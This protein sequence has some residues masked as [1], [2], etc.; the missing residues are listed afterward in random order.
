MAGTTRR[1]YLGTAGIALGS[2]LSAACD[3]SLPL[4]GQATPKSTVRFFIRNHPRNQANRP[5][6]TAAFT[7]KFPSIA[8]EIEWHGAKF[9]IPEEA[10][11]SRVAAGTVPDVFELAEDFVPRAAR[12]SWA[13]DLLPRLKQDQEDA[14]DFY[15]AVL[16]AGRYAGIQVALPEAWS[17]HVMYV[18]RGL[19]EQAQLPLPDHTWTYD[20]W[21]EAAAR[22][23]QA[24][25][26]PPIWGALYNTWGMP[27]LHTLWA[28]GGTLLSTDG[29]RCVLDSPLAVTA[30]QWIA[31]LWLTHR[32]APAPAEANLMSQRLMRQRGHWFW[33]FTT[34]Q[35]GL[36][37]H[38]HLTPNIAWLVERDSSARKT[39]GLDW[40]VRENPALDW[41]VTTVPRGPAGRETSAWPESYGI[42][43][44]TAN[45]DA[46]W[47]WLKF[48]TS[49]AGFAAAGNP[50][51]WVASIPEAR[52]V[53]LLEVRGVMMPARK[54]LADHPLL[55][56]DASLTERGVLPAFIETAKT[57]RPPQHIPNY[58][59]VLPAFW[60]GCQPIW[61]GTQDARRAMDDLVPTI[62][63]L[64]A[65]TP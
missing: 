22:L 62:N 20:L 40:R 7:E 32:V 48:L 21:L 2:L 56:Q 3:L 46:A 36:W 23:T 24:D 30:L 28:W 11:A 60:Q 59:E 45:P 1:Q 17:P 55:Q 8:V 50:T 63:A 29:Q 15:P 33:L 61:A 31:D 6:Q 49:A 43:A 13:H 39:P 19:F 58:D 54:S 37:P 14:D 27:L 47:A 34:G 18:N 52:R 12:D 16:A 35:F 51:G 64:L 5:F 53:D 10:L 44:S 41:A 38:F 9:S 65:K 26:D 4:P 57:L 42:A 25:A